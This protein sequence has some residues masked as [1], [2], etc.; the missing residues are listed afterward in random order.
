MDD[1]P[2][3]TVPGALFERMWPQPGTVTADD[4]AATYL[5][6][7]VRSNMV[8]SI[9]GSLTMDG[10]AGGLSDPVDQAHLHLARSAA[11]VLLVGAGT[12]RAEGYGPV[13]TDEVGVA[14]RRAAGQSDHP[15]LAVVS[16][17]LDLDPDSTMLRD[18]PERPLVLTVTGASEQRVAALEE[19]A[20]VVLLPPG[21]GGGVHGRAIV[22]AV[23]ER[24]HTRILTEGGPTLLGTLVAEDALDE[25]LVSYAP[26]VAGGTGLRMVLG[27]PEAT[28]GAELV[29][30]LRSDS[31]LVAR[32]R[33]R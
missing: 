13:R 19:V 16:T 14:R 17:S 18:A 2:L 25:M 30:L 11:D 1:E 28:R 32:Y 8:T 4:L 29:S 3:E 33:L 7:G 21:E 9:D 23:R 6:P 22:D 20:E 26:V 10:R 27:A 31:L 15:R 24:G 5:E 12:V